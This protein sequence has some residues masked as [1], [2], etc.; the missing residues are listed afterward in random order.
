MNVLKNS[1]AKTKTG[2]NQ[3]PK[4]RRSIV[5]RVKHAAQRKGREALKGEAT[6]PT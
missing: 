6:L 3:K 5:L 1:K 2:K 4:L